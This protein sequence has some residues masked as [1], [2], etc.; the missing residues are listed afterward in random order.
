MDNSVKIE[1]LKKLREAFKKTQE[2]YKIITYIYMNYLTQ[3]N[4]L[5]LHKISK[6]AGELLFGIETEIHRLKE[7]LAERLPEEKR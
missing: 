1:Y 3:E 4:A 7:E 2:A 6:L 5:T